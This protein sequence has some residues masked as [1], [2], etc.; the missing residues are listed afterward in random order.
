MNPVILFDSDDVSV[1]FMEM[2]L[3][4]INRLYGCG[5]KPEQ[6][7]NWNLMQYFPDLTRE[8]VFGVLDD[9]NIWQNLNPIP[10]SQRYLSLLHKEGYEL[11][12]VTATPYSQCHHKCKRLQ[13]LFPFLDDEHIIISHNKQMI[14]GDML[15]DDSPYNL[16]YGEYS[17]ILFDRPHNQKFPNDEY[18][19]HRAKGWSDVYR[20]IH[21][22]FPIK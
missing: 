20:L 10:E 16:V 3:Q 5:L 13:Q 22:I 17:K 1:D 19:M 21:D 12:L 11:Y 6:I 18:D 8:Q 14:R 7:K 4:E 9:I 2:W 15:I